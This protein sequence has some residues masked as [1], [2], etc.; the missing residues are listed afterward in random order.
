MLLSAPTGYFCLALCLSNFGSTLRR[1]CPTVDALIRCRQILFWFLQRARTN[2]PS[3]PFQPKAFQFGKDGQPISP[4][5]AKSVSVWK[6][7]TTPYLLFQP[8]AFQFGKYGQPISP[9]SAKSV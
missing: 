7:R 6:G 8:K 2:N 4:F 9:F 3:L 5:S 1:T